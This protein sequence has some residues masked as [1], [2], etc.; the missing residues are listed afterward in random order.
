MDMSSMINPS[1]DFHYAV[2][3]KISNSHAVKGYQDP[4]G[5]HVSGYDYIMESI[6]ADVQPP[7]QEERDEY[8]AEQVEEVWRIMEVYN[9]KQMSAK[10]AQKKISPLMEDIRRVGFVDKARA[11]RFL[12]RKGLTTEKRKLMER[13]WQEIRRANRKGLMGCC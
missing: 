4:Q 11:E 1:P 6:G 7:P 12:E 3:D 2:Y 9:N 8:Y 10:D 13:Q 5:R